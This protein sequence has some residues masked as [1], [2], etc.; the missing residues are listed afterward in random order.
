MVPAHSAGWSVLYTTPM[1]LTAKSS[2]QGKGLFTDAPIRSR[3]KLGEFTGER[4]ST[5]EARKRAQGSKRIVIVEISASAAIDGSIGGGL[6]QFVNHSCNPNLF[7]R[8]AHGRV[9][10][11]PKQDIN[12]GDE[13]TCDYGDSHHNGT[14]ACRCGSHHCRKY[15]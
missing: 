2:I 8:I 12:A 5:R 9:E 15:L 3:R 1:L 13:L 4:I 14:L 11:Y 7:I 6:F 10:F